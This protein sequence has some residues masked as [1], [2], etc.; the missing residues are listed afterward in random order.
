MSAT[1]DPREESVVF[2]PVPSRRLGRSLGVNNI[3]P[4]VCSYSCAYCQVGRTRELEV[5][6]RTFLAPETLRD[7]VRERLDALK[8]SREAADYVSFVPDGEPSLDRHLGRAIELIRPLGAPVAVISNAS[9]ID[10]EDVRRDLTRADWVSLKVDS[11]RKRT[12]RRLNRPHR[13]IELSRLLDGM[14]RFRDRFEGRL[15]TETMLV[16]GVNDDAPEL[17]AVASL[18]E[19]LRPAVAYISVATR[20]PVERWVRVPDERHL[21]AAYTIL[22]D[23]GVPVEVLA[24][25]EGDAFWASGSPEADLLAITSVHPMR[26]PAVRRLLER[27]GASWDVVGALVAGGRIVEVEYGGE[28]FYVKHLPGRGRGTGVEADERHRGTGG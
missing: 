18:L 27:S 23:T 21:A 8:A 26:K 7:A 11:V 16:A 2:G 13:S 4:K 20:P 14:L 1:T 6:R 28:T 9:L 24:G 5:R 3:P 12:W 22:A 25:G 15:V 10:R 17:D 19:Q